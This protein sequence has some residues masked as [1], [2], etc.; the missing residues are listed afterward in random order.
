MK[1]SSGENIMAPNVWQ[2][3]EQPPTM[4]KQVYKMK[5]SSGEN[6]MA[7]NV[8]QT[9]QRPP[10]ET[11]QIF[12]RVLDLMATFLLEVMGGAGAVWGSMENAGVRFGPNN[13]EFR[14]ICWVTFILCLCRWI[15]R[16]AWG[17]KSH[18]GEIMA[19][20]LL[21]VM[22]GA[23]AMWGC[24]EIAG[25]RVNYPP[26]CK[27]R[28][29]YRLEDYSDGTF[30]GIDNA[31]G[32]Q[33]DYCGN[34]Y[35]ESRI[36]CAI[37]FVWCALSWQRLIPAMYFQA[38][39]DQPCFGMNLEFYARTF[40]LEVMGGAGALWGFS[41]ICGRS[42]YSLRLGWGDVYFGQKSFDFW[43]IP[44][45]ITFILC[46]IRWVKIRFIP[47]PPTGWNGYN[48]H[49]RTSVVELTENTQVERKDDA[50]L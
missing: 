14:A 8:W 29:G 9:E 22:G 38:S 2:T 49:L 39:P 37:V 40:L 3:E 33:Y 27:E 44:C 5:M 36:I 24:L 41:E 18:D 1:M 42:S 26:N 6:I 20:F 12:Y 4:A 17:L 19:V 28:Q 31:W 15:A 50:Q 23:G 10:S 45:T 13:D 21:D 25:Y 47:G 34:T 7:H 48:T 11:K 32:P 35:M 16:E 30:I 43:R 46:F